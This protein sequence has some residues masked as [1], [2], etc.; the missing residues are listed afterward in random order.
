MNENLERALTRWL[1]RYW[2][3]Y[4]LVSLLY[5]VGFILIYADRIIEFAGLWTL[6]FI[7]SWVG[8]IAAL[9]ARSDE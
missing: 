8:L 7:A 9:L 3:H 1:Y 5:F 6:G 4:G 2:P